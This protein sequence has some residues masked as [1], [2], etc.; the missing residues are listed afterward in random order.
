[1]QPSDWLPLLE[2]HEGR[3]FTHLGLNGYSIPRG[4][5]F[6]SDMIQ[7]RTGAAW[8]VLEAVHPSLPSKAVRLPID[9]RFATSE[10]V[11]RLEFLARMLS[12]SGADWFPAYTMH[13]YAFTG[14]EGT[15][16][17]PVMVMDFI[18]GM[19]YA[20]ALWAQRNDADGLARLQMQFL[21]LM[22]E[23]NAGGFDHGDVSVSN[24]RV[25]PSGGMMLLDPDAL[26][27]EELRI[28]RN[29]EVGHQTWNH[30]KRLAEHMDHLH[31]VPKLL[32]QWFNEGLQLNPNL[33][34]DEPDPE[35]F[36]YTEADL[37]SPFSSVRFKTL[38]ALVNPS[39]D[40]NH[41]LSQ[42]MQA[43]ADDY[44][45]LGHHLGLNQPT[46]VQ[47]R[48]TIEYLLSVKQPPSH[49][50]RR[51]PR[52]RSRRVMKPVPFAKEFNRFKSEV[53]R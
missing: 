38:Q 4:G 27:H 29:I 32:M 12:S 16:N 51:H 25:M 19:T 23:M 2:E 47:P 11:E 22:E 8:M 53:N 43:L 41:P 52:Q 21:R 50:H 31:V 26:M 13:A 48:V 6:G 24:L 15:K 35:E 30:P 42:L 10:H 46:P 45:R 18:E 40:E 20:K 1:M 39:N 17:S 44:T 9:D 5:P 33:L 34:K 36:Y 3:L 28:A 37:S 49:F 7:F 14:Q